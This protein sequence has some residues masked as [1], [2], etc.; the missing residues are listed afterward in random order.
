ML[1]GVD[2]DQVDKV[3]ESLRST[4][5]PAPQGGE[6]RATVFVLDASRYEQV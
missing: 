2:A 1:I 5:G 3:I 4:L 6:R